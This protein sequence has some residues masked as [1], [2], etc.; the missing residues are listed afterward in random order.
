MTKIIIEVT[1]EE[2]QALIESLLKRLDIPTQVEE[3]SPNKNNGKKIAASMQAIA[4]NQTF[5]S[6][7]DPIAWQQA[8]RQ[9]RPLPFRD[10]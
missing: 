9:D 2:D 4:N 10:T 7:E 3:R 1:R 6:I 5:R 8:L